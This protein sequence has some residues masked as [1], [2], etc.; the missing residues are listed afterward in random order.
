MRTEHD[1]SSCDNEPIHILG[2]I[3]PHGYLLA[4]TTSDYTIT[5]ASENCSS[6]FDEPKLLN[7]KVIGLSALDEKQR[8]KEYLQQSVDQTNPVFSPSTFKING[9]KFNLITHISGDYLVLEFEPKATEQELLETQT[10]LGEIMLKLNS[11][12]QELNSLMQV[13]AEQVRQ[14]LGYDRVMVYKFWDDWHGEV[15]AEDKIESLDPFLGLHYPASDIP[16]QARALYTKTLTR[17]IVDTTSESIPIVSTNST[18]LDLSNSQLRAVSPV[19]IEYL[20]NMNVGASYSISL[21][22]KGKLWGLIACHHS[23][24][25][26]ISFE[27]RKASEIISQYLS[28]VLELKNKENE[29]KRLISFNKVV[30]KLETQ[31]RQDWDVAQGLINHDSTLI[32]ANDSTGAAFAFEGKLYLT[33]VTPS[34]QEV[35]EII[36]WFTSYRKGDKIFSTSNLSQFIPNATKWNNVASGIL[37]LS[38]SSE[39]DEVIIWFKPELITKVNWAGKTDKEISKDEDGNIRISPR[40]SFEKWTDQVRNTS[41]PWENAEIS[42]AL[43]LKDKIQSLLELKSNEVRRLNTKLNEA[44]EELDSFTYTISHDLKTPLNTIKGYLEIYMEDE[45]AEENPMLNKVIKNADLMQKMLSTV[46]T[47]A[48]MGRDEFTPQR[49]VLKSIFER[50]LSQIKQNRDYDSIKL[51]IADDLTVSGNE[52]LL[53]QVFLNLIDNAIKYADAKRP[54][55]VE[56]TSQTVDDQIILTVRD[57]GIGIAPQHFMKIFDLFKRVSNNQE[58]EGSGVGLAIVKRLVSKQ[59]GKVWIESVLGKGSAFH[60]QLKKEQ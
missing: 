17:I 41:A 14:L 52:T 57:N 43:N 30:D 19:H 44:Y 9:K 53:Y 59:E 48:K 22:H 49:V 27:K 35:K 29:S 42:S 50:I 16:K 31:M 39:P 40:K 11:K 36:S 58:V 18:P 10:R 3:Q 15:I 32:H 26:F 12:T 6:L 25:S 56:I 51:N 1:L 37:A 46:L 4:I 8:L 38:L 33:G 54:L 47:Y 24:D 60:V 23:S 45:E 21:L 20:R 55:E 2:S 13:V 28:Q 5:Y 34:E 7:E